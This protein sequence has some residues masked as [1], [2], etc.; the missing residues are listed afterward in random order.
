MFAV[1]VADRAVGLVSTMILA[2]LLIPSDF[3]LVAMAMALLAMIELFSTFSFDLALIQNPNADRRHYDTAW[4]FTILFGGFTAIV[5]IALAVPAVRFF[6]EPRVEA[7]LYL[8]A[9]GAFVQS[10]QNIG[11]V[12]F[13]KELDFRKEFILLSIQKLLGAAIALTLAFTLRNYWALVLGALC[14]RVANV[15]L[16][17]SLHPY[18]PRLSLQGAADLFAFSRWLLL[19]NVIVFGATRGY[20]LIIG[21]VMGAYSLGLYSVAYEISNLP[22]TEL[23][24]PV[25]RAVFP[26]FAKLSADTERLKKTLLSVAALVA[27]ITIPIAAAIAVLADP[28]VLLLLG[29]QWTDATPLIRLLAIYGVVRALNAGF[30]DAYLATGL[31][32]LLP[33]VNLPHIF[34]GWPLVLYLLTAKGMNEAAL[35]ILCAAAIGLTIN[36]GLALRFLNLRFSE[37]ARCYWRPLFA[38]TNMVAVHLA[39]LHAWPF[40]SHMLALGFQVLVLVIIGAITYSGT[41]VALWLLAKRPEGAEKLI[42]ERLLLLKA[43]AL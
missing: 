30:S 37:V 29:N 36:I 21:R 26:G 28:L 24:F 43:A 23:V 40:S 41:L 5:L 9:L 3:G 2:R 38:T 33:L 20:D 19:N 22:T 14:S 4:T 8:V 12:A 32:R 18:R 7:V 15:A 11:I 16:S 34:F 35:G 42:L 27:V 6:D 13:R 39:L 17:Y 1:R 25:S 31:Y 10:F